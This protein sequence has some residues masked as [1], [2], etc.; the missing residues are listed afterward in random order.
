MSLAVSKAC[1]PDSS[2]C[3]N[4]ERKVTKVFTATDPKENSKRCSN[5]HLMTYCDR[6]CQREHWNKIHKDH[7]RFLS[8]K[9]VK[10]SVHNPDACGQ[11]IEAKQSSG[12][13]I[14]SF[15]SP[16][17]LCCIE[18]ITQWMKIAM[19]KQ[20]YFHTVGKTCACPPGSSWP[21]QLPFSLG[22]VSGSYVAGGQ[23]EMLAHALKLVM[24]VQ[25]KDNMREDTD[26]LI[27]MMSKA[28][29]VLWTDFLVYG[30]VLCSFTLKNQALA[31]T[32]ENLKRYLGY[33]NPWWIA[34]NL[35]LDVL[36]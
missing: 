16:K 35:S 22:E 2:N 33:R 15:N 19:G 17:M 14:S 8:G 26:S 21:G 20:F 27:V 7:C 29:V 36:A 12:A 31:M 13:E 9:I 11:C 4:C 32:L 23:D 5:C 34:L 24:A 28:R 6:D 18:M 30:K 10:N 3:H 25:V 1:F